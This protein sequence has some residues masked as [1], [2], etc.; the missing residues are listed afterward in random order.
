MKGWATVS[1]A[2]Q[3]EEPSKIK[4]FDVSKDATFLRLSNNRHTVEQVIFRPIHNQIGIEEETK[5]GGASG[6]GSKR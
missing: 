4:E 2:D 3:D 6:L 1:I 5:R